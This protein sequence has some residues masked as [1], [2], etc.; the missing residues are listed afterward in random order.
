MAPSTRRLLGTATVAAGVT[1]AGY[2][3][4]VTGAC[5]LDLGIGRRP[6]PLGPQLVEVAAPREAVFDLIAEPYLGRAPRALADK[7]RVLERGSDMVLAAHFTPLGGRLGLVA[8][9]VETV[10]FTRPERVDFRLVRGPVPHVVEA[11]T[12]AEQP[13]GAGTLLAYHGEIAADLW[14]LG[15]RWSELVGR[16]WE[17]TVAASLAAVKAEAERRAASAARRR[18]RGHQPPPAGR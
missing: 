10:R 4:L 13:G 3:G 12:L 14:R 9:T 7:V 17:Q 18:P 15:Q 1:A 2:V 8:Q 16:R 5:P 6:R 11:F